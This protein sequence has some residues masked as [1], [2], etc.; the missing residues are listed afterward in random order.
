M[1][2]Y[3]D[4]THFWRFLAAILGMAIIAFGVFPLFLSLAI[5]AF[6]LKGNHFVCHGTKSFPG[7]FSFVIEV[8]DRFTAIWIV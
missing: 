3:C 1:V 4:S 7:T 2:L 5:T 6:E 8:R